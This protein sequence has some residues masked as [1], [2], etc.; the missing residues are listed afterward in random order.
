MKDDQTILEARAKKIRGLGKKQESPGES[1]MVV[2]F[3]L[4]GEYYS[5]E[6]I[7]VSEVLRMKGLTLI[8]G[9]PSFV[10]GVMNNRGK[11]IPV[12]NLKFLFNLKEKGLIETT[13]II[14][15]KKGEM[16]FGIVAD[17]IEG[18]REIFFN[19][20]SSPPVTIQ[21]IGAEYIKGIAQDGQIL[22]NGDH[23]LT[24][25]TFIVNQK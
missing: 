24:D 12:I 7:Y 16:E 21:G 3:L 6:S 5:I 25:K 4:A 10:V 8:P 20:L 15:L 17:A 2:C 9:A 14:V 1:A 22:L 11:I 18:T 19:T 23:V 13:T